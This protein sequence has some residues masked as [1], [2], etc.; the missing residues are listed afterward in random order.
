MAR[1]TKRILGLNWEWIDFERVMILLPDSKTGQKPIY[2]N[3]PALE[4]LASLRRRPV[5]RM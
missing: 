5:I 2:L 4:A 3:A 1:L